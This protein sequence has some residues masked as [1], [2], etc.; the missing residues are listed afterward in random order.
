MKKFIPIYLFNLLLTSFGSTGIAEITFKHITTEQGLSN[1]SVYAIVQDKRGFMWF[2]TQDG[3]NKFDGYQFTV[4]KNDLVDS[5]SL[6]NNWITVLY[7]D[8][9][10]ELWI[11]S[12]RY[13]FY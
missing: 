3:L 13:E 6:S 11:Q 9:F 10:G 12:S 5:L 8:S 4:Y 1:P 2:G 7:E